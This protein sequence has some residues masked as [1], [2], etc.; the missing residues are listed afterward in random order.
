MGES[1]DFIKDRAA[2][3]IAAAR[4]LQTQAGWVFQEKTI[5]QMEGMLKGIV[6]DSAAAPPLAGQEAVTQTAET[7][8]LSARGLWD[9]QWEV[10][11][12]FTMQ[13]VG[14]A[15]NKF[16]ND[17]SKSA[18]LNGLTARGTSRTETLAEAL[19]W[20][21]AWN[22]LDPAWA[23]LPANTLA[24]F[25]ALRKN[26]LETLQKSYLDAHAGWREEAETLAGL[27]RTMEDVNEAW[28]ADATRVFAAGTPEGD[29]I[30]STVPTTYN[31]PPPPAPPA[32]P[33]PPPGP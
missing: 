6:G 17:S 12:R 18:L 22:K 19:A 32:P 13:G 27:A 30:R 29:M 8:M 5:A 21:T 10:L 24:L 11:H 26:C 25:T 33:T 3:T 20:E 1:V 2:K 15:K 9:Q 23:P 4:Q 14:M 28:Y 31:P 16:R 7:A